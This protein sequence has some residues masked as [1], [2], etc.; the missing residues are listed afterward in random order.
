ME[1]HALAKAPTIEYARR[2]GA[3]QAEVITC[4]Q[5]E[6]TKILVVAIF[7]THVSVRTTA[8]TPPTSVEDPARTQAFQL[9]DAGN[10]WTH[11]QCWRKSLPI[12]LRTSRPR[13][14]GPSRWLDQR[15]RSPTRRSAR[16]CG[17]APGFWPS[18]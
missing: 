6:R 18:N 11:F 7:V 8:Q 3:R 2:A 16:R 14:T 10:M 1:L 9:Y 13:S 5:L 15:Q 12:T 17:H 4:R